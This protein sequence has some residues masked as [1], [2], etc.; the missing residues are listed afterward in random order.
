MPSSESSSDLRHQRRGL[1]W[2]VS[3]LLLAATWGCSF[4]WIKLGLEM[5][6]PVQVAFVRLAVGAAALVIVCRITGA[7]LPRNASTWR[8][9]FVV[10]MLMN[11]IPFTLFAIGETHISSILAGII[12]AATPLT[13]LAVILLAFPEE[14]P[15]ADR[16]LGL[17]IGF[18]GTLIVVGVWQGLGAAEWTGVAACGAAVTCYGIGFPYVR[19]HLSGLPESGIGLATGQVLCGAAVLL[20]LAVLA[21]PLP[22]PITAGPVLG[23]L[24]LGAMGSGIAFA[25]NYQIVRAAGPSTASTVTYLTPLFAIIVGL[26]FLGEQIGWNEPIGGMVVVLG[27]AVAQGRVRALIGAARRA[28]GPAIPHVSRD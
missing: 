19:R 12:N 6:A 9:L 21:G 20:P 16:V 15:T 5:F 10:A 18:G 23:M 13:T 25:L 2:Q 1:P 22:G 3:F 7:R 11:S 4:W 26:L 28:F 14:H 24:G 17:L 27:V 8:H